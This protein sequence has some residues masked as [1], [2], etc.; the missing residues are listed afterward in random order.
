MRKL[1]F[2]GMICAAIF[3]NAQS[4]DNL[5]TLDA[6]GLFSVYFQNTNTGYVGAYQYV[7]KTTDGGDNW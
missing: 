6:N 3:S 1:L 7:Y 2:I 5:G 4:W